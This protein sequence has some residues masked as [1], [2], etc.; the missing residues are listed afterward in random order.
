MVRHSFALVALVRPHRYAGAQAESAHIGCSACLRRVTGGQCLRRQYLEAGL[1]PYGDAPG[2]GV[3]PKRVHRPFVDDF[4]GQV[5]GLGIALQQSLPFK[6]S[7]NALCDALRQFGQLG[8]G[9][10]VDPAETNCAGGV[11]YVH[12]IEKQHVKVEV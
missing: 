9:G 10:R 11:L 2:D 7:A 8:A 3:T 4:T 6:I 1:R 12:P 5:A